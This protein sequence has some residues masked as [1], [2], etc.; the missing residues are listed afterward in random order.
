MPDKLSIY[1]LFTFWIYPLISLSVLTLFL[2]GFERDSLKEIHPENADYM[3]LIFYF[4]TM[5]VVKLQNRIFLPE[6]N[7]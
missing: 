5:V 4:T 3:S 7:Y 2:L 1:Q 6:E